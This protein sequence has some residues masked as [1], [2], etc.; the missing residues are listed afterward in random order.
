[1][2]LFDN[3]SNT[4]N[5]ITISS[6]KLKA[7]ENNYTFS[8]NMLTPGKNVRDNRRSLLNMKPNSEYI[9]TEVIGSV[10]EP[11]GQCVELFINNEYKGEY[12]LTFRDTSKMHQD[13]LDESP[14]VPNV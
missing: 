8:L 3:L 2:Y 10:K 6:G 12:L 4:A 11:N 5:R 14:N 7:N 9:L 13:I 1:M